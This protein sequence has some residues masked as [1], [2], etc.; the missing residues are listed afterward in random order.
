MSAT[1][2]KQYSTHAWVGDLDEGS[3]V[4]TQQEIPS[5][6]DDIDKNE[7]RQIQESETRDEKSL[8]MDKHR[9]HH[10]ET[11]LGIELC[12]SKL[13]KETEFP[14]PVPDTPSDFEKMQNYEKKNSDSHCLENQNPDRCLRREESN[15]KIIFGSMIGDMPLSKELI[16]LTKRVYAA[17]V[18]RDQDEARAKMKS[19]EGKG[20]NQEGRGNKNTRHNQRR[21][22]RK[23][24]RERV[25]SEE[26]MTNGVHRANIQELLEE[27]NTVNNKTIILCFKAMEILEADEKSQE[28][29]QSCSS[30]D[31]GYLRQRQYEITIAT[32]KERG[33][34]DDGVNCDNRGV[35]QVRTGNGNES[36]EYTRPHSQQIQTP[37]SRGESRRESEENVK[38]EVQYKT[39]YTDAENGSNHEMCA[40]SEKLSAPRCEHA[41]GDDLNKH[42][43]RGFATA[44][45]NVF[46]DCD[47][48]KNSITESK[49][50]K[51]EIKTCT[52][53]TCAHSSSICKIIQCPSPSTTAP[54]QHTLPIPQVIL[55]AES[56]AT[57]RLKMSDALNRNANKANQGPPVYDDRNLV[58][59]TGAPKDPPCSCPSSTCYQHREYSVVPGTSNLLAPRQPNRLLKEQYHPPSRIQNNQ[60]DLRKEVQY[61]ANILPRIQTHKLFGVS[62]SNEN[63][64]IDVVRDEAGNP[65]YYES[66]SQSSVMQSH[67]SDLNTNPKKSH[68]LKKPRQSTVSSSIKPPTSYTPLDS[69]IGRTFTRLGHV[70]QRTIPPYSCQCEKVIL[71]RD[72]D[73]ANYYLE[74]LFDDE[75]YNSAESFYSDINEEDAV[76]NDY[77]E[78]EAPLEIVP[79]TGYLSVVSEE[80][81]LDGNIQ[82]VS[83]RLY[84]RQR[85]KTLGSKRLIGLDLEWRPQYNRGARENPT[86]LV[87]VAVKNTVLLLQV[88]A[89]KAFPSKLAEILD[90][91]SIMKAGVG[92]LGDA[93][94][95]YRDFYVSTRSC[96]EL[97]YL[98]RYVEKGRWPGPLRDLISLA[99]LVHTYEGV[100][101]AKGGNIQTSNWESRLSNKQIIYAA[102]D[103]HSGFAVARR[104]LR[105]AKEQKIDSTLYMFSVVKGQPLQQDGRP[106]SLGRDA[107]RWA[108]PMPPPPPPLPPSSTSP[109]STDSRSRN[110]IKTSFIME[111]EI[112]ADASGL[113]LRSQLLWIGVR[114]HFLIII[115]TALSP[116]SAKVLPLYPLWIT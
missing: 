115:H 15:D 77:K 26:I 31:I 19:T 93:Q 92:I 36:Q 73:E 76:R 112:A 71:I 69:K 30:G 101:L 65:I 16:A 52:C 116:C 4:G 91:E 84:Q 109:H 108:V 90:D 47:T 61:S 103:A 97:S 5:Q 105:R 70:L 59:N 67:Q 23:R 11:A 41:G 55:E 81:V 80:E 46:L 94:R 45:I 21:K 39:E 58:V 87:Q 1:Q 72:R 18:K 100:W 28:Y 111:N 96:I 34:E 7:C 48:K 89:M 51:R 20:K 32:G 56:S 54:G 60:E 35:A 27:D 64:F 68:E 37:M 110:Q 2:P 6:S 57:S 88:S 10:N 53:E 85:G 106:W 114:L 14:S 40:K 82:G 107:P 13:E 12:G 49:D 33:T 25:L 43:C 66:G 83:E 102:N 63:M 38:G 17:A 42:A 9:R 3:R 86:A 113:F 50:I 99:R 95:L 24:K 104:L 29:Y 98:A 44:S 8:I 79:T 78:R 75:L 62:F 74:H 22:A